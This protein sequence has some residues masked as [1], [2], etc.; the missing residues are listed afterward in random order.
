MMLDKVLF[1]LAAKLAPIVAE[2]LLALLPVVSAAVAKAL[3]DQIRDLLPNFSGLPGGIVGSGGHI[4]PDID[5]AV[6]A[7]KV[8]AAAS[9]VLPDGFDIPVLSDIGHLFGFDL[10][11]TLRGRP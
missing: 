3:M 10:T 11:D 5:V 6:L 9:D 4:I 7:E 1:A 8:R 2:K